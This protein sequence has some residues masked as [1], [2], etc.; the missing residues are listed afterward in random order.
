MMHH[1]DARTGIPIVDLGPFTDGVPDA[2]GTAAAEICRAVE[3]IGFFGIANHGVSAQ[4]V[5]DAF[6]ASASFHALPLEAKLAVKINASHRGYMPMAD[7]HR[8]EATRPN[9]SESFLVGADLAPDDPDILAEAPMC[10]PNQWP[11]GLPG[12]RKPLEAYRDTM[13]ALGRRL[14]VLFETALDLRDG[15]F[16]RCFRKPLTFVRALHYPPA[17]K[18]MPDDQFGAAPHSDF[19][20][21]TILAQDDVGGLQVK[22]RAGSWIDAPNMPG[23][24]IVNVGDMLMRWTNDRFVSTPHRVVNAPGRDRYSLPFFFDPDV[25]TV[26]DC[27]DSCQGPGNPPRYAPVVW[28]DF[29]AEKFNANHK[30]RKTSAA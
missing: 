17:P 2:V 6:A 29:L 7:Q 28:G 27:I 21:V 9:L 26:V 30:Y 10:G 15:F 14:L 24:F 12:I 16:Q 22:T 23:V 11:T 5:A 13:T 18:T 1:G 25:T 19:G 8:A 4:I 3:D 20:F